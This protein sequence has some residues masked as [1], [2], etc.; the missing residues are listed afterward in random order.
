MGKQTLIDI[1]I[2]LIA[3]ILLVGAFLYAGVDSVTSLLS[4]SSIGV[5]SEP[6]IGNEQLGMKTTEVLKELKSIKFNDSIFTDPAFLSLYDFTGTIPET[7]VGRPYPFS[8][9]DEVKA[10]REQASG[11]KSSPLSR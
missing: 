8:P 10:L 5:L 1:V 7:A 3:P 4:F 2:V 6:G 11:N 9:S